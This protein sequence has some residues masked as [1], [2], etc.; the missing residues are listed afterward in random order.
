M[1]N[2]REVKFDN[3]KIEQNQNVKKVL[4]DAVRYA[5]ENGAVTAI[6][7]VISSEGA[8]FESYTGAGYLLTAI[9]ALE[10][11]KIGFLDNVVGDPEIIDD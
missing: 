1:T 5:E 3:K 11:V 9:G 6:C 4:D 2:I 8:A 7:V 10:A